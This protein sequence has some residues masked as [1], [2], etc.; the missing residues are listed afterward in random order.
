MSP[1][2]R[3][4]KKRRQ[5]DPREGVCKL[6]LKHSNLCKSHIVPESS[7]KP[8]YDENHRILVANQNLDIERTIRKGLRSRILCSNCEQRINKFESYFFKFWS[9][10]NVDRSG[11]ADYKAQPISGFDYS[12]FKFFHLS[13]FWRASVA[14]SDDFIEIKLGPYEEKI[15]LMLLNQDPGPAHQFPIVC[16]L[17]AHNEVDADQVLTN[18]IRAQRDHKRSYCCVHSGAEWQIRVSES[19]DNNVDENYQKFCIKPNGSMVAILCPISKCVSFKTLLR[20]T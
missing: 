7:Y 13:V 5:P 8:L 3:P 11:I 6:C 10:I 17:F 9:S 12:L 18:P 15:R 19:I 20:R 2:Q 1:T 16:T 4:T 14:S